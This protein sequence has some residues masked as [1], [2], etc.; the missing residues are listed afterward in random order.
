MLLISR[1]ITRWSD[2]PMDG[3]M[4]TA[5]IIYPPWAKITTE[6]EDKIFCAAQLSQ[7][8]YGGPG[9]AFVSA[10]TYHTKH[11]IIAVVHQHFGYDI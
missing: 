3:G 9:H 4:I 8:H 10:P 6:F 1:N 2:D 7:P 5:R 11:N